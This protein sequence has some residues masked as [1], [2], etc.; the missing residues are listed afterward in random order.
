MQTK[1]IN[2]LTFSSQGIFLNKTEARSIKTSRFNEEGKFCSI[3]REQLEGF[4]TSLPCGHIFDQHCLTLVFKSGIWKCPNCRT[5]VNFSI[6]CDENNMVVSIKYKNE[7]SSEM[8]MSECGKKANVCC[9]RCKK[10]CCVG[11]INAKSQSVSA[12]FTM[13][14]N[15]YDE[16]FSSTTEVIRY[17]CLQCSLMFIKKSNMLRHVSGVHMEVKYFCKCCLIP[18]ESYKHADIKKHED[19]IKIKKMQKENMDK[20]Q[21]LLNMIRKLEGQVNEFEMKE[22]SNSLKKINMIDSE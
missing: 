3:K 7:K 15:C 10:G 2:I 14:K 5:M 13:C 21:E 22:M 12:E 11:C 17:K 16:I 19:E 9:S 20:E 8:C 18:A 4:Y 1:I 6:N